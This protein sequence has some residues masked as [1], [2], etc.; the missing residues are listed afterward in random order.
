MKKVLLLAVS[1]LAL[2]VATAHADQRMGCD[3]QIK[4]ITPG[5]SYAKCMA[6]G[7]PL[8]CSPTY[9]ERVCKERFPFR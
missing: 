2:S 6:N 8:K 7:T 9:M 3:G 5:T 4:N 1:A